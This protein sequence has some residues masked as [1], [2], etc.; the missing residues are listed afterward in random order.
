MVGYMG[1]VAELGDRLGLL[2]VKL[3]AFNSA[4][5]EI[6]VEP[7]RRQ[8]VDG[9]LIRVVAGVVV[10]VGGGESGIGGGCRSIHFRCALSVGW[11]FVSSNFRAWAAVVIK[12]FM[13]DV[14]LVEVSTKRSD[15][16]FKPVLAG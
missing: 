3:D 5:G 13:S 16:N 8:V 12:N 9:G 7:V 14:P 2:A 4:C 10:D 6:A 11:L 1:E 15:S